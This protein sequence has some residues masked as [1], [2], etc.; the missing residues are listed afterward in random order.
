MNLLTR[1]YIRDKQGR[2]VLF[3]PNYFSYTT[4]PLEKNNVG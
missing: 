1:F 2:K 4:N 3:K